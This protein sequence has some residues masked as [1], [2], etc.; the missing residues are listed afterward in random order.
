[1]TP[2]L[3]QSEASSFNTNLTDRRVSAINLDQLHIESMTSKAAISP[4]RDSSESDPPLP[5][6]K[7]TMRAFAVCDCT[8]PDSVGGEADIDPQ[9]EHIMLDGKL[10]SIKELP[11][12]VSII[13]GKGEFLGGE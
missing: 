11:E 13:Q 12:N 3:L 6:G 10:I 7:L 5:A 4:G 1:V 8:S 9:E 2:N